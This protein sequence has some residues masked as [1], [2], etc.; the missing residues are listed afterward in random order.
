MGTRVLDDSKDDAAQQLN[1]QP[2]A[3]LAHTEENRRQGTK[4]TGVES[5]VKGRQHPTMPLTQPTSLEMSSPS[6]H[7]KK[8]FTATSHSITM[9]YAFS[10][11]QK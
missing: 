1:Q 8:Y 7:T 9:T 11:P 6:A 5:G 10:T 2:H 4:L 3:A